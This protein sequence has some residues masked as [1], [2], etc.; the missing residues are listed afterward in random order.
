MRFGLHYII[1]AGGFALV[2][3]MRQRFL[4]HFSLSSSLSRARSASFQ[5]QAHHGPVGHEL[6]EA[7]R[8]NIFCRRRRCPT[9]WD[10][11]KDFVFSL[12]GCTNAESSPR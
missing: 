4:G 7:S 8:E 11:A 1:S 9:P 6:H 3:H 12:P 2:R 5:I 10:P